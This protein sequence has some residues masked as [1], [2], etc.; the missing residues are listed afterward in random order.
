MDNL[1]PN[2]VSQPVKSAFGWHIIEVLARKKEDNTAEFKR[3]QVRLF[4]QQRKFSEAVETWQQRLRT[5][6]YVKIIDKQLA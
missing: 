3:Q 4:L 2:Q 1:Q 5:D 6:A